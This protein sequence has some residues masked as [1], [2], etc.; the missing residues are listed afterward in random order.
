MFGLLDDACFSVLGFA[1]NFEVQLLRQAARFEAV[2]R[3]HLTFGK[4]GDWAVHLGR[5]FCRCFPGP[6]PVQLPISSRSFAE[7][8]TARGASKDGQSSVRHP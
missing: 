8:R 4:T 7:Q 2:S 1:G 3:A 6:L 5:H